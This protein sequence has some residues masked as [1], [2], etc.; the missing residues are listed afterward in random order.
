MKSHV[1]TF[2]VKFVWYDFWVGFYWDKNS[3][4]L[5]FCPLPTLVFSFQRI[6]LFTEM[7]NSTKHVGFPALAQFIEKSGLSNLAE[8]RKKVIVISGNHYQYISYLRENNLGKNDAI[9]VNSIDQIRGLRNI[10]V[11]KYG[12][13][14]K[15]P[16]W[17]EPGIDTYL[18]IITEEKK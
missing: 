8:P 4:T 2:K 16:I 9:F 17:D 3:K 12:E 10:T 13:W 7:G 6:S 14:W 15:N 18:R 11:V 1:W 5:Y